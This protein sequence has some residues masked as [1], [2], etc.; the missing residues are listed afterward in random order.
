ML[1]YWT[2]GS[3][4]IPQMRKPASRKAFDRNAPAAMKDIAAAFHCLRAEKIIPVNIML[5]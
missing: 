5:I 3:T 1:T 2:S 4:I